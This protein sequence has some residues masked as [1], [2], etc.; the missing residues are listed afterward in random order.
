[1][2]EAVSDASDIRTRRIPLSGGGAIPALGFGTL[3]GDKALTVSATKAAL[4]AGFRHLDCA[5]RYRNEPEVA[6]A[7]RQSMREGVS[8]QELF[9]T[10]KVWN[11]NHRPGRVEAA[12]DGSLKRLRIDYADL[13]LVH[14]P[15]AFAPGDDQDPRDK[16]GN[17]VYDDGVTLLETW[18][19]MERLVECG[20]CRA[21]GLSDIGLDKLEPLFD[22][23][24]IKPAV[25]Q[26]EAHPYLPQIELLQ[27]CK[28]RGIVLLAFAPVGHGIHP[29]PLDDPAVE[30]IA[31]RIGRTPGQVLLAWGVQRGTAVLTTPKSSGR[32]RENFDISLL[33]DDAMREID[34][35]ET[36]QRL[37]TVV[38]T[39]VPGFIARGK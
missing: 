27:F 7:L 13:Y 11:T 17:V 30:A 3:V 20:K 5:E 12:C 24:R 29:G 32:A 8:R 18:S 38:H 34:A 25:L 10:T 36:R 26:V 19:A 33:P 22:A 37:N 35:I 2:G 23:A 14:T 21:I 15:F 16:D 6:E 9:I 1:M 31:K 39:G 28:A 4:D